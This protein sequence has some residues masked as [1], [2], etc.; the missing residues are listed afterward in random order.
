MPGSELAR[1]TAHFAVVCGLSC[2]VVVDV[3][4]VASVC[5]GG[6]R[7]GTKC[8]ESECLREADVP[9]STDTEVI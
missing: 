7:G 5:D 3:E 2:T 6:V 1:F 4:V 9:L 8:S